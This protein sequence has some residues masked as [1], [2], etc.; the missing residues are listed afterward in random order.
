[1]TFFSFS[2]ESKKVVVLDDGSDT[3]A[4]SCASLHDAFCSLVNVFGLPLADASRLVSRNPAQFV[5]LDRGRLEAGSL[6][7]MVL[8]SAAPALELQA[9]IIRGQVAHDALQ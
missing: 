9:T 5:G 8:L 7:D 1:M 6:A 3:I 2:L 4:G